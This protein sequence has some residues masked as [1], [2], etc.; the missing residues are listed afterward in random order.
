MSSPVLVRF[1]RLV[2]AMACMAY[3][4]A[5]VPASAQ[6]PTLTAS[7]STVA[8]GATVSVTVGGLPGQYFA[9][10]GS[11][12]GAGGSFAGQPLAVG[13]DYVVI[14][15]GTLDGT[16]RATVPFTPPFLGSVIDRVYIQAGTSATPSYSPL[17][18][19][20]GLILRNNDLVAG[21][22][23]PTGP[24]GPAG[25]VGPQGLA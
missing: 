4:G 10:I 25:P 8:P 11:I 3:A 5:A 18:L 20:A 7:Q 6:T 24:A 23:G 9:V 16:G 13:A 21:I 19:S 2:V 1:S 12:V 14:A 17:A 22:T 15:Q